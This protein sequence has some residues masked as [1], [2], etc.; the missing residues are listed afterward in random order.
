MS[1]ETTKHGAAGL[2]DVV[3]L[4]CA[5]VEDALMEGREDPRTLEHLDSCTSCRSL[6]REM[7]AVRRRIADVTGPIALSPGFA[8]EVF[9]R[10][11]TLQR[12][13]DDL[14]QS[15]PK[16]RLRWVWPTGAGLAVAASLAL[17]FWVGGLQERAR[18]LDSQDRQ[19]PPVIVAP[20]GARPSSDTGQ[21]T[22]AR[23]SPVRLVPTPS[24][25]RASSP[26]VPAAQA[27][28]ERPV[29]VPAELRDLLLRGIEEDA[30]CA[31]AA[32]SRVRVTVT[33]KPD[34]SLADRQI[35]SSGDA[36]MAHRCVRHALDGLLLPPGHG[37]LTVTLDVSW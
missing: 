33:V 6:H 7:T 3:Q 25:R 37:P 10:A 2:A 20:D 22:T 29:D 31:E 11:Q 17:A 14:P 9:A 12:E 21:V 19:A 35:L 13:G 32:G 23:P 16:R 28:A 26:V 36:S 4:D 24:G 8:A 34:G 27:V 5:R 30:P 18:V 1:D 15:D